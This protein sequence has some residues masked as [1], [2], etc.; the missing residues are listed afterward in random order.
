M[1]NI[2]Y[3]YIYIYSYYLW[4]RISLGKEKPATKTI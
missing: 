4:L 1:K 3:K 2:Y